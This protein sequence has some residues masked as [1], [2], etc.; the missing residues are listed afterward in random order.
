MG[1]HAGLDVMSARVESKVATTMVMNDNTFR[2]FAPSS[3]PMH[4]L[5]VPWLETVDIS[6]A[7]CSSPLMNLVTSQAFRFPSMRAA[8]SNNQ[9]PKLE[10]DNA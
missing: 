4:T 10:T 8:Y 2:L 7:Y 3:Q 5:P 9:Q 6:A 1:D